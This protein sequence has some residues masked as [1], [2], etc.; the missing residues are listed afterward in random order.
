MHDMEDD[1]DFLLPTNTNTNNSR[2][3][4]RSRSTGG[5]VQE[6]MDD[7]EALRLAIEMSRHDS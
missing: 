4:S 1:D 7:D 5:H 2:S 6:T 3:R